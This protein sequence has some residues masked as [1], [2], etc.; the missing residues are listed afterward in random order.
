M[1]RWLFR[2]EGAHLAIK[3]SRRHAFMA[4]ATS[5]EASCVLRKS[6]QVSTLPQTFA[7]CPYLKRTLPPTIVCIMGILTLCNCHVY[8]ILD[9]FTTCFLHIRMQI[10]RQSRSLTH[11]SLPSILHDA[12]RQWALNKYNTYWMSPASAPACR[13][14]V[15]SFRT[16]EKG[17]FIGCSTV[18]T[19]K[20]SL[21]MTF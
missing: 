13:L 10:L 12:W 11:C 1:A 14:L 3:Y 15:Y 9:V 20:G 7:D 19:Q 17:P 5:A 8:V 18:H 4:S 16:W 6:T 21:G 2:A